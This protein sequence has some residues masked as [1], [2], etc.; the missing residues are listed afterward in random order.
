MEMSIGQLKSRVTLLVPHGHEKR[1][2]A[3][4]VEYH[5]A[6]R[7]SAAVRSLKDFE[8]ARF[9]QQ[10]LKAEREVIIRKRCI[11]S[12]WRVKIDGCPFQIESVG[13]DDSGLW[14]I[15]KVFRIGGQ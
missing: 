11:D 1:T 8:V 6:A 4:Q 5:E 13:I 15:L 14:N 2:G 9:R 7:V 12:T 3:G 10:A